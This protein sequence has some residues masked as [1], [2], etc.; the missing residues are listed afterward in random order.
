MEMMNP[1]GAQTAISGRVRR[2]SAVLLSL[3]MP[4]A[5]HFLLGAFRRGAAWAVGLAV[6][7]L[8]LLFATPV[9]LLIVSAL[10]GVVVGL[11]GRVATA[12]DTVRIVTSRPSWKIVI[13]AWAALLVGDLAMVEP[14]KAYYRAHYAQAF[15]IPSGAMQ[16]TLL[17]GDYIMVDKSAYRGRAPQRGDIVVFAY[18]Q[19]ERRDFIKRIIGMPGD[20]VVVRGQQ[21]LVNDRALAEPYVKLDGTTPARASTQPGFCAYAYA[22]EPTKVP[23]D[24]YFVMGDNRDN[25]QDSRSWGFVRR[26]KIKG[27]AYM[28]YW[29]WDG[30]RHWLRFDRIGRSL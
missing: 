29:S 4:G 10:I 25:S 7:G 21:V 3:V 22:C 2:V 15:T 20:T 28:I 23:A 8:L 27:K 9:S 19:D 17:V 11:V 12:I 24:S 18:P 16:P 13:V 6:L 14:L 30:D 5:G 26:E 1:A